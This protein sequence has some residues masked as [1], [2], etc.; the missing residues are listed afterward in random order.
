METIIIKGPLGLVST[1][2][3]VEVRYSQYDEP[4]WQEEVY[5]AGI[6]G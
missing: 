4:V 1:Y 3:S 2:S 6:R 5:V